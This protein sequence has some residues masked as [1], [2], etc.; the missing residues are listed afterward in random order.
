MDQRVGFRASHRFAR[1]S[2]RKARYVMDLVRGLPVEAALT[3]LRF[4]LKRAAPMITKV[5][6]SALANATQAAGLEPEKL[7]VAVAL[8]DGGPSVKRWKAR[9]MGRPRPR[10]RRS[11]H[12]SV[13]LREKLPDEKGKGRRR[14]A[15][16]ASALGREGG[17]SRT[18][19]EAAR[20]AG[21]KEGR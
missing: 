17:E 7:Y 11:C 16:K 12:L 5:I 9:A 10:I 6:K 15:E 4:S 21:G 2:A 13:V 18:G 8:V 20:E 1:I 3:D 14:P 19:S